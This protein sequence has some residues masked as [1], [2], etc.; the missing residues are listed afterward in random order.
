VGVVQPPARWC[1]A[2]AGRWGERVTRGCGRVGGGLVVFC[3]SLEVVGARVVVLRGVVRR[4]VGKGVGDGGSGLVAGW[5]GRRGDRV[6]AGKERWLGGRVGPRPGNACGLA[7]GLGHG[8]AA[9]ADGA[10]GYRLEVRGSK[11][12]RLAF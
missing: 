10:E 1:V 4:F 5:L 6:G 9:G 11:W 7:G 8:A 3:G 2:V 12:S